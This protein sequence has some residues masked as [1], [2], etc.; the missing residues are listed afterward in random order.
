MKVAIVIERT[1]IG[2]ALSKHVPADY[3]AYTSPEVDP[4]TPIVYD[5]TRPWSESLGKSCAE[6]SVEV[7]VNHSKKIVQVK[8]LRT[9]IAEIIERYV[10]S[11]YHVYADP[12]VNLGLFIR[13]EKSR[14]WFESLGQPLAE[15]GIEMTANVTKK[16]MMLRQVRKPTMPPP[17]TKPKAGD[18][19]GDSPP[20]KVVSTNQDKSSE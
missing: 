19:A 3:K 12:N 20:A 17:T 6:V 1:T 10:P 16:V 9:T 13:Y 8:P 7:S 11:D 2:K 5:S 4:M 14:E 15:A 18:R